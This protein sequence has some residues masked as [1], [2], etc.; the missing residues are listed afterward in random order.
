MPG[1]AIVLIRDSKTLVYC[2]KETGYYLSNS[3]DL[4]FSKLEARGRGCLHVLYL[5]QLQTE[6]RD[7]LENCITQGILIKNLKRNVIIK[8]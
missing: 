4:K 7:F 6:N 2:S 5:L 3:V 8:F 1:L